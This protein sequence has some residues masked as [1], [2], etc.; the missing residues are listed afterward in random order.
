MNKRIQLLED[1]EHIRRRPEMYIGSVASSEDRVPIYTK[2]KIVMENRE[3]SEGFY[4][5]FHE[6][7]DNA[8]DEARRQKGKMKSIEVRLDTDK[9]QITVSDDGGGFLDGHKKNSKSGISH[10]E[11]AVTMLKAGS[12]FDNQD[13]DVGM[14]GMHGVG[15]TCTNVLSDWFKISSKERGSLYEYS[16]E[17]TDFKP[18]T[19]NLSKSKKAKSD[20]G[21]TISFI[22]RKE[23]FGDIKWDPEILRGYL[24]LKK[25]VID[26]SPDLGV[27]K[28]AF[29]VDGERQSLDVQIFPENTVL[30]SNKIGTVALYPKE[31]DS[32]VDISFINSGMCT[33]IHQTIFGQYISDIHKYQYA[34]RHF[35]SFIVL[36]LPSSLVKF[37]GQ[38]KT[39]LAT[40]RK[41]L[42]EF[43]MDKFH[44]TL[45]REYKKSE[46]KEIVDKAIEEEK[47]KKQL[48]SIK[49]SKRK[50][51][52]IVLSQKWLPPSNLKSANDIFIT[53]G[54][55]AAGS[56]AQ[57]R[58][59]KT[60]GVYALKGKPK[61]VKDISTLNNQEFIELMSILGLDP[62]KENEPNFK[63][64]II[65]TDADVDGMHIQ[66]LMVNFF[67]RWFPNLIEKGYVYIMAAP[68]GMLDWKNKRK[69]FYRTVEFEDFLSKNKGCKN[70]KY[71]KGLGS[72]SMKDW[73]YIM[74]NLNL[75]KVE[76]DDFSSN[77]INLAFGDDSDIRKEYLMDQIGI[78]DVPQI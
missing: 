24:I 3:F 27:L 71:A 62:A 7:F 6:V 34:S 52:K 47:R 31:S 11:T 67:Y 39:R 35:T 57:K 53:E 16:Q 5:I 44:P 36:N 69:F 21:V 18:K 77:A 40:A 14:I 75:E 10:I 72:Y 43:L 17:W 73:E 78:E 54:L 9:N 70:V 4:K 46:L 38:N 29:Y 15:V 55:S 49:K 2:N 42:E 12:N 26:S 59:S 13:T 8:Y 61:N 63:R 28:L 64:I 51:N 19:K 41:D 76:I 25:Y 33:G 58:D 45:Q 56:L 32:D 74:N 60:Q 68:I 66:T 50:V 1:G 65:A 37:S 23:T 48:S 30:V 20:S 22:P